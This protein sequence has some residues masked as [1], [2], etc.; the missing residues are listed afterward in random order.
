MQNR[1]SII[2]F[3]LITNALLSL[4]SVHSNAQ[5]LNLNDS[6]EI[7]QSIKKGDYPLT[8]YVDIGK[9]LMSGITIKEGHIIS[10]RM[11]QSIGSTTFTLSNGIKVHY[12]F[13]NKNKNDVQF[14]AISYGGLSLVKDKDLPSAQ[15]LAKI[16]SSSGLGDHSAIDLSRILAGNTA[17]TEIHLSNIT[18]SISGSSTMKDVETLLQMIHLRFVKP[19]FD[20]ET[21]WVL[22]K[23]L[24]NHITKRSYDIN[25][26]IKDSITVTLY[27]NRHPKRRLFNN[28]F[29]KDVYFEKIK[30]LYT[31]RF[32]NAADFEFF[33][34]GDLQKR[35]LR[36]LLEK[37]IAS[38]S[39][40][41]TKETWQDNSVPWLQD[42]IIKDIFLTMKDPKNEVRI[43]YKNIM[44]YSL[45]NVLIAGVLSDILELRLTEILQEQVGS[46][47]GSVKASVQK[48]LIEQ[49]NLQVAFDCNSDKVEQLVTM[50][51]QEIKNIAKG[52][53][54][55][56]D[57]D[58]IKSNYLKER[59]QEQDYNNYDMHVLTN[60]FLEGYNMNDPKNF[61][62]LVNT[63][64]IKN[65][66]L[67]TETLI[68]DSKSY[69][70]IFNP[71]PIVKK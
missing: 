39:T 6:L 47:I 52:A 32:N 33:I 26:R 71:R 70:I 8:P 60:Y 36:P 41:D 30:T 16:V 13:T 49:A 1:F 10:E 56:T 53:I 22:I 27:G 18:E 35:M 69:K 61:E 3:L 25:E 7:N 2:S 37:Y 14:K 11:L 19:R 59:K 15:F 21:Y 29:V 42:T 64:T 63:I 5:T 17:R 50:I 67:F 57:L 58:K 45:K 12:K 55:Q 4:F 68:K 44:S 31:E 46:Y 54:S 65:I 38:I 51:H 28:D 40:N 43:G 34:V 9:T 23:D 20:K 62:D 24:N 48:R 66:E